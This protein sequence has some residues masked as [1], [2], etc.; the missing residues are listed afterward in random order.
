MS[1][2]L[3]QHRGESFSKAFRETLP[4][5]YTFVLSF[6]VIALFWIGHHRFF[7]TLRFVDHGLV[8]WNFAYLGIVALLPFPSQ[9][10]GDLGDEPGAVVLYTSMLIIGSF[11]GAFLWEY[12]RRRKLLHPTTPDRLVDHSI[13]HELVDRVGVRPVDSRRRLRGTDGRG[14]DVAPHHPA[15]LMLRRRYGRRHDVV[16]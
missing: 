16:W 13:L 2:A 5:I 14:A 7:A 12:A 11:V 4:Q 6:V 15:P 9:V 1:I 10:L 8:M 3:E